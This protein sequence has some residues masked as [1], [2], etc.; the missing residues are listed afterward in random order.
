MGCATST[1]AAAPPARV[2]FSK[3]PSPPTSR[4]YATKRALGVADVVLTPDTSLSSEL[5]WSLAPAAAALTARR[6]PGATHTSAA[7]AKTLGGEYAR[8]GQRCADRE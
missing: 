5:G 8:P 6:A 1:D 4:A 3:Q 2:S 7:A